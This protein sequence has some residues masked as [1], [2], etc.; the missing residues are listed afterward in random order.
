MAPPALPARNAPTQD[1]RSATPDRARVFATDGLVDANAPAR[2]GW[3]P[4]SLVEILDTV[5][6]MIGFWDRTLHNRYANRGY[7]EWFGVG[8]GQ[9]RGVHLRDVLGPE[10]YD[11]NLPLIE[12]VLAG[13]PQQFERTLVAGNRTRCSQVSYTPHA[14]GEQVDGFFVLV[15]DITARAEAEE[16]L[17]ETAQRLAL[18]DERHRIAAD[19]HDLVIQRLFAVALELSGVGRAAGQPGGTGVEHALE[20]IGGALDALRAAIRNLTS[21]G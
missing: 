2:A 3:S 17:R 20:G 12:A 5:P 14:T 19:L 8:S 1:V 4:V 15:T 16:S 13:E 11:L 9:M 6:A 7:E 10:V 18:L 21:A